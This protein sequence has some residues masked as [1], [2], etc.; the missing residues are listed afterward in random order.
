MYKLAYGTNFPEF[1]PCA[2]L[3]SASGLMGRSRETFMIST[4][5][6]GVVV[7]AGVVEK[8]GVGGGRQTLSS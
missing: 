3:S 7:G 6:G 5:G 1:L 2:A 8:L 4:A